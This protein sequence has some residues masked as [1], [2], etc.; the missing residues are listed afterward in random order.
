MQPFSKTIEQSNEAGIGFLW[1][2]VDA[3]LTFLDVASTTKSEE[4][5]VRN[6]DN[7]CQ[8]YRTIL[9]YVGRVRFEPADK[10]VF[11]EKCTRLREGLV[12]AGYAV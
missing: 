3:A 9:R 4:T 11:E 7:A 5:A 10:A 8:A 1:A 6:R 2:E 12:E